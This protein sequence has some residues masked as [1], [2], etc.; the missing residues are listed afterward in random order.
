MS[1][2]QANYILLNILGGIAIGCFILCLAA[3]SYILFF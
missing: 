1:S 2:H 3:I